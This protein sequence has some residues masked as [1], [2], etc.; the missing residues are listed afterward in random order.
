M[1]GGPIIEWSPCKIGSENEGNDDIGID[2]ANFI[3]D[4][5]VHQTDFFDTEYP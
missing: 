2:K 5:Y 4:S 3:L 1:T